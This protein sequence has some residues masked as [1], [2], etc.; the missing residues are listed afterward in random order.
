MGK[1]HTFFDAQK[2]SAEFY[3]LAPFI[4]QKTLFSI[5]VYQCDE[6]KADTLFRGNTPEPVPIH[7]FFHCDCCRL[8]NNRTDFGNDFNVDK[9]FPRIANNIKD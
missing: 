1:A 2:L 8:L 6:G 7:H 5:A 9:L 3:D 4:N